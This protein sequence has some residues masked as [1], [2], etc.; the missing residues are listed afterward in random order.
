MQLN[1]ETCDK[2]N[3]HMKG[4]KSNGKVAKVNRRRTFVKCYSVLVGEGWRYLIKAL[5]QTI[6]SLIRDLEQI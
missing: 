3:H 1:R 4:T 2:A 5:D 6:I